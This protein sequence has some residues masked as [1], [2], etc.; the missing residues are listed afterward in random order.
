MEWVAGRNTR[1]LRA[2]SLV[3]CTLLWTDF[4]PEKR[5]LLIEDDVDLL[6]SLVDLLGKEGYD[7][8]TATTGQA[9]LDAYEAIRPQL[10]LLD[11][12]LPD[13]D[14]F[15]VLQS[16]R[17]M[18]NVPILIVS[19]SDSDHDKVRA[20]E[21]GADDYLTKPFHP[22][23]LCA[24]VLALLRR[25]NRTPSPEAVIEVRGLRLDIA[26]RQVTRNGI[27]LHLTPIEF[28]ILSTLMQHAGEVVSHDEML[29]SVWGAYYTG[30]FSVLRVNISRLRQKIETR[31][32]RP[33]LITTV[34]RKGYLMPSE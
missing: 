10:V 26:R 3:D 2:G 28:A 11:I 7:V 8:H 32:E 1:H 14:G 23:E 25:V 20:L 34:A 16:L 5:L 30:D 24:R 13:L 18:S 33:T 4:M 21:M 19:A 29:R 9:G 6:V 22:E 31:P 27:P 12:G 17:Q 15:Q